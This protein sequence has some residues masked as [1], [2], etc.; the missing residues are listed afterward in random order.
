[1]STPAWL[2]VTSA[3]LRIDIVHVLEAIPAGVREPMLRDP[4]FVIC[5]VDDQ[6]KGSFQIPVALPMPG[7][8]SRS[9]VLKRSL[10]RRAEAFRLWVIAHEL[11][12]AHLHNRGRSATEDPEAAADSLAATWGFPKPGSIQPGQTPLPIVDIVD[13]PASTAG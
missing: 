5:E 8:P 11:A 10:L 6:S 7:K 2:Q 12:H 9:V 1:M 4:S 13:F 3:K